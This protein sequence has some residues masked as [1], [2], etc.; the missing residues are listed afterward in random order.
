[1][2]VCHM[3]HKLHVKPSTMCI[4]AFHILSQKF[5][6]RRDSKCLTKVL[7]HISYLCAVHHWHFYEVAF[8]FQNYSAMAKEV[9]W[10]GFCLDQGFMSQWEVCGFL[11]SELQGGHDK[12]RLSEFKPIC[13]FTSFKDNG[14]DDSNI[15]C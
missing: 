4:T 3:S 8:T 6:G 14:N 11:L 9:Q 15:M 1:M 12:A 10:A 2:R 13:R 7:I 5:R